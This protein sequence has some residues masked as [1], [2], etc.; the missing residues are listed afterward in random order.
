MKYIKIIILLV[1]MPFFASCSDDDGDSTLVKETSD[2]KGTWKKDKVIVNFSGKRIRWGYK[3]SSDVYWSD[4]QY[5]G[6]FTVPSVNKIM[7]Y[8][9]SYYYEVSVTKYENAIK[10]SGTL[11]EGLKTGKYKKS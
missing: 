4:A 6:T 7:I 11:P 2:L 9:K 10:L 5:S 8:Y 3:N 1:L